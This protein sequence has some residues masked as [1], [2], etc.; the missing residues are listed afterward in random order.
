[1]IKEMCELYD[2]YNMEIP[3]LKE[4]T[5]II[6]AKFGKKVSIVRKIYV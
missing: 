1:M 6:E 3:Q 5:T 2:R 4:N